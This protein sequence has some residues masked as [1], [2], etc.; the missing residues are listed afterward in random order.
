MRTRIAVLVSGGGT[1]LQALLDHFTALGDAACGEVVLVASNRRGA[2]ALERARVA[3]VDALVF[4]ARS[5]DDLARILTSRDIDM[6]VLAGYLRL[7]PPGV[8]ARFDGRIVNVHPGPLP[9]FGGAGMYGRRV[10]EAV[11]ASGLRESAVTVHLVTD[12]YDEG[13]E[14]ATWPV[15]VLGSDTS[16]TLAA[17]VLRVEHIVFPRIVDA[18]AATIAV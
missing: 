9:R 16:D 5:E 6:I 15:P 7:V 17:R 18:L 12:H 11:L 3:G 10:H 13:R 14:L 4:D 1:N 2:G 8:I